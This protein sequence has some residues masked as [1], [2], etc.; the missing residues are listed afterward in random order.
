MRV[1]LDPDK[2]GYYT[3]GDRKTYSKLQSIEWQQETGLFPEWNF[4]DSVFD[5]FDWTEEPTESLWD[6]YKARARQIR[7]EYDYVV[8]WYSGGSDSHNMLDA[9][10]SAG[11]QIDE[12][13]V[14]WNYCATRDPYDHQNEEITRVVLTRIEELRQQGLDFRFRL[15]DISQ[16]CIDMIDDWGDDFG[17]KINHHFSVNNPCKHI[18]R[19]KIQ[20][21][22]GVL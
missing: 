10:I 6:L 7:N 3:V 14:T 17:Y 2:F 4:N 9:W 12:I 22:K 13:A 5:S 20:D 18:L 11:L 15:V 1:I 21:Y 19:D 16:M 8:L